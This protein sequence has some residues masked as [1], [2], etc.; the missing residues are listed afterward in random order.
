LYVPVHDAG[1]APVAITAPVNVVVP[2][3][4]SDP[5][6]VIVVAPVRVVDPVRLTAPLCVAVPVKV[7]LADVVPD[8]IMS[9]DNDGFVTVAVEICM[10]VIPPLLSDPASHVTVTVVFGE[11]KVEFVM[12]P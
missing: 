6:A 7:I 2:A 11:E 3:T 10:A 12:R 9:A 8:E 5:L 4:S 1:V